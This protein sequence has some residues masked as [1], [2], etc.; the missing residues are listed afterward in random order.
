MRPRRALT[1]TIFAYRTRRGS[2]CRDCCG[3]GCRRTRGRRDRTKLVRVLQT[4]CLHDLRYS[5]SLLLRNG[6]RASRCQ[7]LQLHAALVDIL[8]QVQLGQQRALQ[9]CRRDPTRAIARRQGS[10]S[11]TSN[12]HTTWVRPGRRRLEGGGEHAAMGI[13]HAWQTGLT[14]GRPSV[15]EARRLPGSSADRRHRNGEDC[16]RCVGAM[17]DRRS[18]NVALRRS[19]SRRRR[20]AR[21]VGQRL[22]AH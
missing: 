22:H 20:R 13:S 14:A 17:F 16:G 18:G 8:Q 21:R 3:R 11:G 12:T 7:S 1:S 4:S 5:H 19:R 15:T 6:R 10:G 9:P 2:C